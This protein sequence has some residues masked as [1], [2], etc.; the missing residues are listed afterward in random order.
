M[1]GQPTWHPIM[2]CIKPHLFHTILNDLEEGYE[3]IQ[4]DFQKVAS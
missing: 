1:K 2:I 3:R 4:L